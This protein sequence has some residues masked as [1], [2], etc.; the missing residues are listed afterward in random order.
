[1]KK[2]H[3]VAVSAILA[4][5]VMMT[6]CIGSHALFNKVNDWNQSVSN[7]WVNEI[8]YLAMWIVPVYEISMLADVLV[9]NTIEFWT[10]SNPIAAGT[11][12]RVK[13]SDGREYA[14]TSTKD[15]YKVQQADQSMELKFDSKKKTWSVVAG[16]KS[17]KLM[18][19]KDNGTADVCIGEGRTMSVTL[20]AAGATALRQ[21]AEGNAY[22]AR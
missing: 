3:L 20:D 1:M 10:G 6:S 7:K 22:A 19:L 5:S 13:G 9:I 2:N 12:Q 8:L 21:Y 14:I 18:T 16:G 17:H 11:T 15:G 4:G